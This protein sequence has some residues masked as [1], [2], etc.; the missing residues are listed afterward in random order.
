MERPGGNVSRRITMQRSRL[1]DA[2]L[3]KLDEKSK[4]LMAN[5]LDIDDDIRMANGSAANI[6]MSKVIG[7]DECLLPVF[8]CV[9]VCVGGVGWWPGVCACACTVR[10]GLCMC[11]SCVRESQS[12]LTIL[13]DFASVTQT[14]REKITGFRQVQHEHTQMVSNGVYDYA[15]VQAKDVSK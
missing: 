8:C 15:H 5:V 2:K 6:M 11:A 9:C 7:V 13:P 12:V 4:S 3:D 1:N 10:R 14:T